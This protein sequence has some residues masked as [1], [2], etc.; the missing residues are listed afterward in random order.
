MVGDQV[1]TLF[2]H[3]EPVRRVAT[4]EGKVVVL[5]LDSY[6]FKRWNNGQDGLSGRGRVGEWVIPGKFVEMGWG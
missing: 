4:A 2:V 5:D 1:G 6:R 3:M